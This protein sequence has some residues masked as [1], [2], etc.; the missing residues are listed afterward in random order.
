M[1]GT[2][3]CDAYNRGRTMSNTF[4]RGKPS[5]NFSRYTKLGVIYPQKSGFISCYDGRFISLWQDFDSQ[6]YESY[7][8]KAV[9]DYH[10]DVRGRRFHSVPRHARKPDIDNQTAKHKQAIRSAVSTGDYDVVLVALRK[11]HSWNYW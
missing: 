5:R 2:P 10:R 8:A 7:V 11:E 3:D 1:T 6:T 9:R 4:R